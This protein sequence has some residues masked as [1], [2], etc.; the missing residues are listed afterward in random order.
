MFS[1][2]AEVAHHAAVAS[3]KEGYNAIDLYMY[4]FCCSLCLFTCMC[5][6]QL[7]HKSYCLAIGRLLRLAEPACSQPT[8]SCTGGSLL[9]QQ[10]FC[11]N[12]QSLLVSVISLCLHAQQSKRQRCCSTSASLRTMCNI[13][14]RAGAA[15]WCTSK[16]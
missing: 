9:V 14:C 13:P 2:C 6:T 4:H 15:A 3:S 10:L 11:R 1:S 7:A 16:S 8:I 12:C 5:T